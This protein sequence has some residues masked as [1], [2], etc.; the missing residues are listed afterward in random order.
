M[1]SIIEFQFES[2]F[3]LV[4]I[5]FNPLYEEGFTNFSFEIASVSSSEDLDVFHRDSSVFRC[6]GVDEDV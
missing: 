3:L 6:F 1:T 2:V 5:W 4:Q